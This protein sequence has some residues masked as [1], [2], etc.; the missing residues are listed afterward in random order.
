MPA[1]STS[2]IRINWVI[3]AGCTP[4]RVT[5]PAI[6]GLASS[7]TRA[8]GRNVMRGA[9]SARKATSKRTMMR[10]N[11]RYCKVFRLVC[12]AFWLS[13]VVASGPVR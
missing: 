12:E 2:T 10:R 5:A 8:A 1:P 3:S 9:S 4:R 13:T 11:E 6:T 7:R